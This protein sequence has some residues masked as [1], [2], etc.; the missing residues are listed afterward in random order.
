MDSKPDDLDPDRPPVGSAEDLEE[1]LKWLEELTARQ[2]KS[3]D[4]SNPVP[5]ASL[6]SPFRGLIDD[7]EGDLPDWLREAQTPPADEHFTEADAESR[8]DWLAKMAQRE[9]IEELP[10]LEWR[11]L[12][13]PVQSAIIARGQEPTAEATDTTSTAEEIAEPGEEITA[14]LPAVTQ[15]ESQAVAVTVEEAVVADEWPETPTEPVSE[16]SAEEWAPD[17]LILPE[18]DVLAAA[19]EELRL[20][21]E[22]GEELPPLDDLDA[23]MAW[24]EELAASQDAPIE[25]IPSVADR[26]LASKLMMEAGLSPEGSILDEL[27][28]DSALVDGL[29]P[30]HPF[31]EE[32]DFADTVVLVETIAADQGLTLDEPESDPEVEVEAV[33]ELLPTPGLDE[34]MPPAAIE[35]PEALSF[36]DAMAILDEIAV[37]QQVESESAAEPMAEPLPAGEDDDLA[38]AARDLAETMA[39]E[40]SAVAI[41]E[42]TGEEGAPLSAADAP[43]NET[44]AEAPLIGES[45]I[46]DQELDHM[47][48]PLVI[49]EQDTLMPEFVAEAT[50]TEQPE[51]ESQDELTEDEPRIEPESEPDELALVEQEPG[52][53]EATLAALDTLALPAGRTLGDLDARL[54]TAQVTP[55]RDVTSALDWLELALATSLISITVEEPAVEAVADGDAGWFDRMPEDPDA[56][57]AW[58]EQM[59]AAEGGGVAPVA[60]LELAVDDFSEEGI[61]TAPPTELGEADLLA[62]PEDPDEAMAWLESLAHGGPPAA[63]PAPEPVQTIEAEVAEAAPEQEWPV[64]GDVAAVTDVA[65]E[66]VQPVEEGAITAVQVASEPVEPAEEQK[67]DAVEAAPSLDEAVEIAPAATETPAHKRPRGRPRKVATQPAPADAEPP[68]ADAE[69][70]AAESAEPA[71]EPPP[72]AARSKKSWVDLL[73]PLD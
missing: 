26:A 27:G 7:A 64:D 23:A 60:P 33:P 39:V 21:I 53:L 41:I 20:E 44:P 24:I 49:E 69:P 30:T 19:E 57:L 58:L 70:Q 40:A 14:E 12:S 63:R 22:A 55:W 59:A 46:D 9:S 18:T 31:I 2:S 68:A 66:T 29:T 1:A 61:V 56:V 50:E 25:E 8:L 52:A 48:A 71:A 47:V 45:P 72:P 65:P 36:E 62:M 32:E 67:T 34:F 43:W 17:G 4:L 73:K 11:R 54:Q 13:E 35:E 28:S 16:L 42:A 3:T 38:K 37:A 10:T 15:D 6:D 51:L 5:A